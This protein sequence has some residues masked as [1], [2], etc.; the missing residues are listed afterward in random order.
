MT[1]I[2]RVARSAQVEITSKSVS[3]HLTR[4]LPLKP[5]RALHLHRDEIRRLVEDRRA[6]NWVGEGRAHIAL[7]GVNRYVR[8]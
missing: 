1:E 8:R 3:S 7:S 5:S 6:R 4:V 2:P